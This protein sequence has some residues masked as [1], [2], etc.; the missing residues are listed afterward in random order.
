MG[1]PTVAAA[2]TTLNQAGIPS[3]AFPDDAAKAFAILWRY[4]CGLRNL[5][6]TPSLLNLDTA[7]ACDAAEAIVTEA[8][9]AQRSFL[10]EYESKK[11]LELYGILAVPTEIVTDE[12]TAVSIAQRIGFPVVLKLHS[13]TITHKTDV[14]GVKLRL[15]DAE[16]V[17][18]AFNEIKSSPKLT[19]SN[20]FQGVTVQPMIDLRGF[21]LLV[22]S[23]T[24]PQFG[25]VIV[26]GSGGTMVEIYKDRALA[27]PPL[28]STLAQRLIERTKIYSALQNPREGTA[29]DLAS[30]HDLLV[31]FSQLVLEQR[32]IKEI[33]INP[34]VAD[35]ESYVALDAR[36]VLHGPEIKETD[37]PRPAIRPYPAQY[38]GNWHARDGTAILFRPIRPE[39]EPFIRAFHRKLSVETVQRRYLHALSLDART[40][41]ERLLRTCFVDYDREFVLVAL[42]P[43]EDGSEPQIVAVGRLS[44]D[45]S[46]K[47]Y[48][49]FAIVIADSF[50]GRGIGT[51]LMAR[52]IE[53]GHKEG[54]RKLTAAMFNSNTP[55][56]GLSRR[57][58]FQFALQDGIVT[59]TR[60]I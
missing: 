3:F 32:W 17:R 53:I 55:M 8:R 30:L 40:T 39:D 14:G 43:N 19:R 34:L 10:T 7:N 23:S 49:E 29:V 50:Q 16:A 60:D 41:H 9:K 2:Q 57:F 26:F 27:L 52:L 56:M 44:R 36:V 13:E 5:Y 4:S 42:N 1:G 11:I 37:L 15:K 51:E 35:G 33:D 21:E 12:D 46:Q 31:R 22:G 6:E 18:R 25:P 20:D 24:D 47:E 28:N 48:G 38:S 59:A 58:G 45:R 54:I